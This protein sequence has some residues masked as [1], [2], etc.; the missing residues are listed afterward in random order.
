MYTDLYGKKRIK[1]GLHHHTTLSDGKKSPEEVAALYRQ[2]GYDAIAIT[3]HWLFGETR[4]IGEMP[5]LSGAEYN[6][7][8]QLGANTVYHILGLCMASDPQIQKEMPP[9]EIIDRIH[10]VGGL[11]IL[12]HP[13]WSLNTPEQIKALHGIDATEIYNTVSERGFSRRADSSLIVD[14][15]AAQGYFYPLLAADDSH[16][17]GILPTGTVNLT[18]ANMIDAPVAFIMA[19]AENTEPETIRRAVREG[20]FYASTGPEIHLGIREDGTAFVDCS[21]ASEIVFFSNIAWA[22]RVV[23][24]ENLTHGEY[25]LREGESYLRAMVIDADGRQAWTNCIP[26]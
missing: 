4:V 21:P 12:A 19:E 3:D 14:L 25:I 18:E 23:M 22:K 1:L 16:Y 17:Y 6:I 10:A 13:A 24:G 15:L 11:A 26:L 5:I 7:G 20:R 9:Q 2:A 8:G